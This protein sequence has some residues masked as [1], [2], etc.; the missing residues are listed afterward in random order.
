MRAKL[1]T[2][3]Y[4]IK[5]VLILYIFVD[6]IHYLIFRRTSNY[7]I[8]TEAFYETHLTS[9]IKWSLCFIAFVLLLL[10]KYIYMYLLIMVSVFMIWLSITKGDLNYI[11]LLY[12]SISLWMLGAIGVY[13][14]YFSGKKLWCR[15]R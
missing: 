10:N 3:G 1:A 11:L 8:I 13:L 5:S 4:R 6:I 7:S 14:L 9:F 15:N 12:S 2:P